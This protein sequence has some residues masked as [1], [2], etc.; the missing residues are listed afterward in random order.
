MLILQKI[1]IKSITIFVTKSKE[2]QLTYRSLYLPKFYETIRKIFK[3]NYDTEDFTN[4]QIYTK[5][6]LFSGS[7]LLFISWFK[8]NI[9]CYRYSSISK[10]IGKKIL[11]K[12]ARGS[13]AVYEKLRYKLEYLDKKIKLN[14]E[15]FFQEALSKHKGS[16]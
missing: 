11:L 7:S 1:V 5:I 12:K 3:I 6:K 8:I 14:Y 4:N 13:R 16:K 2:S 15:E 9:L 10:N